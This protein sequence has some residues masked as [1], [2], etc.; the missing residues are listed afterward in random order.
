MSVC[1]QFKDLALRYNQC[2]GDNMAQENTQRWLAL[3]FRNIIQHA[4]LLNSCRNYK[5]SNASATDTFKCC[6]STTLECRSCLPEAKLNVCEVCQH[7][8]NAQRYMPSV[9]SFQKS[10]DVIKRGFASASFFPSTFCQNSISSYD[11]SSH[12]SVCC[13]RCNKSISSSDFLT[14]SSSAGFTKYRAANGRR[15]TD[16]YVIENLENLPRKLCSRLTFQKSQD[17]FPSAIIPDFASSALPPEFTGRGCQANRTLNFILLDSQNHWMFAKS[18]G[19]DVSQAHLSP[20][21]IAFDKEVWT[22][23]LSLLLY[24]VFISLHVVFSP[25]PFICMTMLLLLFVF[26]S[27]CPARAYE[28]IS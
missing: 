2:P 6:I 20:V 17:A 11:V 9:C 5:L 7:W 21:I 24:S 19:L 23:S 15:L 4:K 14:V 10:S 12:T 3:S 25:F 1:F 26:L 8:S 18:L 28:L 16:R 13:K 22:L 27:L